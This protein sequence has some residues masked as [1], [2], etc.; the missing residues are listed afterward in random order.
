MGG[1]F[2]LAL[3]SGWLASEPLV[4]EIEQAVEMALGKNTAVVMARQAID[5]AES[6]RKQ[7]RAGFGPRLQFQM[8][9]MKFNE[10]P[11][12]AAGG[13]DTTGMV[14]QLRQVDELARAQ[15]SVVDQALSGALLGFGQSLAGLSDMFAAN[16]Y[17]VT[18]TVTAAQ[19]LSQL[20]AVY[21]AYRLSELELD[22]RR[23]ALEKARSELAFQVRQACLQLLSARAVQ[24]A[25]AGAVDTVRAHVQ[26][27]Q[28]FV[29]VGLIGKND[30]LQAEARL[31]ELEGNLSAARHGAQLAE[32]RLVMLL[33]LPYGTAIDV[34]E[35]AMEEAAALSYQDLLARAFSARPE[36]REIELRIEQAERGEK[37]AWQG[38]IPGLTLIGQYQHNEG[39]LMLP[40]AWTV[41]VMVDFTFWEWGASYYQLEQARSRVRRA[42]LALDQLRRGV[43][44][45]VQAAWLKLSQA[46]EQ[47]RVAGSALESARE[48]LRLERERYEV[49]QST[50]TEVLDAQSRLTQAT[51]QL[52]NAGYEELIARA[53]LKRAAG[54]I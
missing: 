30:L 13:M 25:L 53:A 23:L 46:R 28:H 2:L 50:T 4:L 1:T 49:Q 51:L 9:A 38:F 35:P 12:L 43:E 42:R 47:M 40:P 36:L 21:Q 27:A 22:I 6:A 31:A 19:P 37:A 45:E 54:E 44:L 5:E 48:Q 41:G 10:P 52:K 11:G 26:R 24:E 34:K 16:D 20:W 32:A 8:R 39:S 15:G 33:E 7:A 14:D 17:D 3:L 29:E 18:V